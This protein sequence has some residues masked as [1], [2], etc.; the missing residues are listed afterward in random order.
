MERQEKRRQILKPLKNTQNQNFIFFIYT[1]YEILIILILL[2][3]II[4]IMLFVHK[5]LTFKVIFDL[6]LLFIL[7]SF[8]IKINKKNLFNQINLII[9]FHFLKKYFKKE[10]FT[11][12]IQYEINNDQLVWNKTSF[13]LKKIKIKSLNSYF[14]NY[15][16]IK[17]INTIHEIHL[18]ILNK[19]E[20]LKKYHDDI[21]KI[22]HDH[23]NEFLS[24]HQQFTNELNDTTYEKEIFIIYKNE[25]ALN[26]INENLFDIYDVT[27]CELELVQKKLNLIVYNKQNLYK[28]NWFKVN[29]QYYSVLNFHSFN[30]L[31]QLSWLINLID[32]NINDYFILNLSNLLKTD[33]IN[34]LN[35]QYKTNFFNNKLKNEENKQFN[36]LLKEYKQQIFNEEENLFKLNCHL[37]ITANSLEEL[38]FK[39]DNYK[40]FYQDNLINIK[41]LKYDYFFINLFEQHCFISESNLNDIYLTNTQIDLGW[42]NYS[43]INKEYHGILLG[44][45]NEEQAFFFNQEEY[46]SN[47]NNLQSFN[48][49]NLILGKS[50]TGKSILIKKIIYLSNLIKHQKIIILDIEGEYIFLKDFFDKTLIINLMP[51]VLDPFKLEFE[52]NNERILFLASF[53]NSLCHHDFT[54]EVTQYFNEIKIHGFWFF[55]KWLKNNNSYK[56][57]LIKEIDNEIYMNWFNQDFSL[58]EH[59]IVIFNFKKIFDKEFITNLNFINASLVLVFCI[60]SKTIFNNKNNTYHLIIDEAH[61]FFNLQNKT[62]NNIWYS[63]IKKSRK[64]QTLLTFATQNFNDLYANDFANKILGNLQYLF[65]GKLN[66]I[67]LNSLIKYLNIN[68]YQK[69]DFKNRIINLKQTEFLYSNNNKTFI[70]WTNII[71]EDIL[72]KYY[73][74]SILE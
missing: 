2:I 65:I 29:E 73:L 50:G 22:K 6:I 4:T 60:I 66:D 39:T 18:M 30:L 70:Q 48:G 28:K 12:N 61:K 23:L 33:A 41:Q 67:D 62:I 53:L 26:L 15:F 14:E 72:K 21:I 19:N 38:K 40:Y 24:N 57:N 9:K 52:T 58:N 55:I 25:T 8:L 44:K 13:Y 43:S 1:W 17:K 10:K 51:L 7:L 63:L 3:I 46:L 31:N 34:Y 5:F 56:Y 71:D 37:I 45:N 27:R 49:I 42:M 47:N 74:N 69:Q 32:I 16:Q 20:L 11:K 59:E 54:S 64:Y 36:E 68:E 35:K